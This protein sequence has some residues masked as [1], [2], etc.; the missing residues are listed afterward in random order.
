M[1]EQL[2][3]KIFSKYKIKLSDVTFKNA[4]SISTEEKEVILCY[5]LYGYE[6]AKKNRLAGNIT[7]SSYSCCILDE[8]LTPHFGINY[9]AT[10]NETSSICAE[11]LA[12]L[13]IFADKIKEFDV[14]KSEGFNF[15]IKYIL[16]NAYNKEGDYT[17]EKV[18]PCADCLS[19]FNTGYHLSNDSCFVSLKKMRKGILYIFKSLKFFFL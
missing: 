10:R 9:N 4:P 15:K 12:L 18:T 11:R 14:E 3:D 5:L 1:Q 6:L 17:L 7:G 8:K 2:K 16:M 13:Q 19:W